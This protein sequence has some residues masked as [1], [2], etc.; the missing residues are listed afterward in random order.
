VEEPHR[1]AVRPECARAVGPARSLEDHP[2]L[3]RRPG[4]SVQRKRL[5]LPLLAD[6]SHPDLKQRPHL[7][8]VRL[9]RQGG[10]LHE[11]RS[12]ALVPQ[13]SGDRGG[14]AGKEPA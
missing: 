3:Q 2:R 11:R 13:S 6:V 8:A 5:H 10:G 7:L 9:R 14:E 12:G 4:R 1:A